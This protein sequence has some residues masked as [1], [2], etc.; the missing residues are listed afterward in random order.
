[1]SFDQIGGGGVIVLRLLWL[2]DME[3]SSGALSTL[4]QV[5]FPD[6]DVKIRLISISVCPPGNLCRVDSHP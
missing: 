2:L 3:L 5:I 6:G 1:M 4:T